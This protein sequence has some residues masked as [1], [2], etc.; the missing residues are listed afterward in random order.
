MSIKSYYQKNGKKVFEVYVGGHDSSGRR[1]QFKKR[2][3]P[4]LR[5]AEKIQFEFKRELAKRK[6]QR[7]PYRWDEWFEEC[8]KRM[9][10]TMRPSTVFNYDRSLKSGSVPGGGKKRFKP[11]Q[12]LIFIIWFLKRW[13]RSFLPTQEVPF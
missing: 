10:L 9:K 4:T 1:V 7:I 5:K 12:K 6:E 11:S 8:L 3:V 13:N 2:S